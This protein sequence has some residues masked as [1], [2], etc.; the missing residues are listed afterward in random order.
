MGE[1]LLRDRL[2]RRGVE[3]RVASAGL[4]S[5]DV[6]ASDGSVRAMT[7]RGLDLSA[8]R[9]RR[10]TEEAVESADL[11]LGM[12]REHV[13]EAVVLVPEALGRAFTLREVVRR[14]EA[15]GPRRSADPSRPGAPLE[16]LEAWL[17]RVGEGRRPSDLL[18]A[19]PDDDIPD[20]MGMSRR[21][22]ERTAEV[23]SDLVDRLVDLAFPSVASY[24]A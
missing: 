4:V 12:A 17:A 19:S 3:A 14:A 18:G 20:P 9:S 22:Y 21:A 15:V 11:V 7:R 16:P 23:I 6:P 8:H 10:L 13:R 2:A 1:A 24:S 5:D